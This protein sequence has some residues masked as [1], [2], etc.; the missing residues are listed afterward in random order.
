M[1]IAPAYT[2]LTCGA[3]FPDESDKRSDISIFRRRPAET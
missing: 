1:A 3:K 2:A